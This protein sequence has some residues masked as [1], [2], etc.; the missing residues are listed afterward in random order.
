MPA[1]WLIDGV[2]VPA[3]VGRNLAYVAIGGASGVIE[4]G[5]FKVA[6]LA[7]PG[8]AVR[9]LP[10]A[11]SVLNRYPG[12]GQQAYALYDQVQQEVPV[13][14]TSSSGAR[15]DMV[16]AR[17]Y[18]PEF[19]TIPAGKDPG[20]VFE[21]LQSVPTAAIASPAGARAYC[22]TL[23]YPAEPLAGITQPPS[24]ATVTAGM[25]T[26]L[27][28]LARPRS[29]REQYMSQV[30]AEQDLVTASGAFIEWPSTFKP[31][32]PIPAWAT[33]AHIKA[34]L[35]GVYAIVAATAGVTRLNLGNQAAADVQYDTP[36]TTNPGDPNTSVII[37]GGTVPVAALAG[38]TQAMRVTGT[39]FGGYTGALRLSAGR[40]SV[41]FEVEFLER[42]V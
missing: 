24:T 11:A 13:P 20:G 25:V 7:V 1:A 30:P 19:Q 37:M 8:S 6:P 21:L 34:T 16:I 31:N 14:G 41:L 2:D 9:V 39:R 26:D 15:L 35:T 12:G 23:P 38:T 27:R 17:V 10:G 3:A 40:S 5:G 18:D 28:A 4:P 36:A 42:A 33:D 32:V 29:Q 22:A